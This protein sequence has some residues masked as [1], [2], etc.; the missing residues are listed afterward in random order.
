MKVFNVHSLYSL[1]KKNVSKKPV[2]ILGSM[3]HLTISTTN[4]SNF[5]NSATNLFQ[6]NSFKLPNETQYP[7]LRQ[8]K[9]KYFSL[10]KKL[11]TFSFE[12]KTNNIETKTSLLTKRNL[13]KEFSDNITARIKERGN[14]KFFICDNNYGGKYNLFY[15]KENLFKTILSRNRRLPIENLKLHFN[16]L[17]RMGSL[18]EIKNPEERKKDFFKFL[19]LIFTKE[20]YNNLKYDE[21]EI[22]GHL[23]EYYN[24][25]KD[26]FNY[27]IQKE[28][29]IDMNYMLYHKFRT[30]DYGMVELIFNSARIDI[31]DNSY[32]NNNVKQTINIPFCLMSL[33]FL[34]K[35]E[36][37]E[38]IAY[39]LLNSVKIEENNKNKIVTDNR[40]RQLFIQILSIVKYEN[41]EIKFCFS[42]REYERYYA[43]IL[44]LERIQS[45]SETIRYN[46]LL[47]DFEKKPGIIKIN[48]NYD[49]I[50]FSTPNYINQNKINLF[51]NINSYELLLISSQTNKYKIKFHMPEISLLYNDYE[52]QLNHYISN[53]LFIYLYQNN[54]VDWDFYVLHY[55]FCKKNF[56]MF[57]GK[58]LSIKNNF[59]EFLSKRIINLV[60]NKIEFSSIGIGS[61]NKN[62]I[63]NDICL[64]SY[65]GPTSSINNSYKK[66]NL[67]NLYSPK[68]S[69]N[70]NDFE[71]KFAILNI[72]L[73]DKNANVNSITFNNIDLCKFKSYALYAF[74]N[75]INKPTIYEFNFNFKQMRIL[76]YRSQYEHFNLF[77]KR[78]ICIKDDVINFDYSYFDSFSFMTNKEISDYFYKLNESNENEE[79]KEEDNTKINSL[80]LKI[81][82]PH[83]E[84]L[85]HDKTDKEKFKSGQYHVELDKN[86]LE[87][88]LN[89][90]I[91]NWMKI[92]E[93]SKNLFGNRHYI[94]YEDSKVKKM[95]RKSLVKGI[96]KDFQSAFMQFLKLSSDNVTMPKK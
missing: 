1:F 51:N 45:V 69:I 28:K 20:N 93:K 61:D 96:K 46:Y 48:E 73:N 9:S 50:I 60:E 34:C 57:I 21:N 88:L 67:S 27:Y 19:N 82:D 31:I 92:I 81:R 38:Q 56:R 66:Y 14:I 2:E 75:N 41:N 26:E 52:K 11:N 55:L 90:K 30:K 78:L 65:R 63:N 59:N 83:I 91:S 47:S 89:N 68:I 37:L 84:V 39:F 64:S 3:K 12:K 87:L 22:F 70:E 7:L 94:K 42:K 74:I 16:P 72:N 40:L 13:K 86:F 23:Q 18:E 17:K 35:I 29:E 44:F 15:N 71:F 4:Y 6:T 5:Y 33:I 24:F 54:F 80:I 32:K 79:I 76:Y 77:F 25:I 10:K 85:S 58:V 36:Q 43:Q 62:K 95:K 8:S 49:K 53:E